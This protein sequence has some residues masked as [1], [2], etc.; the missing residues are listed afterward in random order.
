MKYQLT[1]IILPEKIVSNVVDGD[2]VVQHYVLSAGHHQNL[3]TRGDAKV[4]LA[5]EEGFQHR[6]ADFSGRS[7]HAFF[8]SAQQRLERM[9]FQNEGR[10]RRWLRRGDSRRGRNVVRRHCR[11]VRGRVVRRRNARIVLRTLSR[12]DP[13]DRRRLPL[14][15]RFSLLQ[16]SLFSTLGIRVVHVLGFV[17]SLDLHLLVLL[18]IL[19]VPIDV[20]D[21]SIERG[22]RSQTSTRGNVNS[23]ARTFLFSN[24][25]TLLDALPTEPMEA[26]HHDARLLHVPQTH[27]TLKLGSQR[28]QRKT[29]AYT[30][31]GD[32][33]AWFSVYLKQSQRVHLRVLLPLRHRVERHRVV[34]SYVA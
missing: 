17:Q 29:H 22:I 12:N 14:S 31:I 6:D 9:S 3:K 19:D 8:Q 1:A 11:W 27:G 21:E 32:D 7:E 26:L 23:A 33:L 2:V 10:D 20:L 18:Q 34:R 25:K 28:F 4:E 15:S 16:N 30:G 5:S 13:D 24:A